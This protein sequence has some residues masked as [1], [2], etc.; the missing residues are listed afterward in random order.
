MFVAEAY[1][2]SAERLAR[3][4]R[5]DELHSAFNFDLLL[6]RWEADAFR[7]VIDDSL[8]HLPAVGATPT[9]VLSNHDRVRHRTRYGGGA[10]GERAVPGRRP[11]PARPA[12]LG[13]P[14]PGRG[15]RPG[16]G[17]RPA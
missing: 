11:A 3:Y 15:A 2:G 13:L 9:W 8:E 4:V 1:L 5:P 17:P 16:G 10:V 12:R 7:A 6:A 14:L